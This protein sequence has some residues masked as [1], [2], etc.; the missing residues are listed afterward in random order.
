MCQKC[1]KTLTK[2][3]SKLCW[4]CIRL[5]VKPSKDQTASKEWTHERFFRALSKRS[6]ERSKCTVIPGWW[7]EGTLLRSFLMIDARVLSYLEPFVL[8]AFSKQPFWV[9]SPPSRSCCVSKG[10]VRAF[11][12]INRSTRKFFSFFT[13]RHQCHEGFSFALKCYWGRTYRVSA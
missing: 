12:S 1:I 2:S 7:D 13:G 4:K 6:Y 10:L 8:F 3:A 11:H 9:R 5:R